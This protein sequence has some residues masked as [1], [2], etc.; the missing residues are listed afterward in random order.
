M[1]SG[2]ICRNTHSVIPTFPAALELRS[3][4]LTQTNVGTVLPPSANLV[5]R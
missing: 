2:E 3:Y 4:E 1:L 5:F